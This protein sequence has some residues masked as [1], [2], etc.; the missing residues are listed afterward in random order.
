MIFTPILFICW[1][2]PFLQWTRFIQLLS[3]FLVISEKVHFTFRWRSVKFAAAKFCILIESCLCRT[4]SDDPRSDLKP[5]TKVPIYI[6]DYMYASCFILP[7]NHSVAWNSTKCISVIVGLIESC[8]CLTY[9]DDPRCT[10]VPIYFSDYR[11]ACCLILPYNCCAY[12]TL[13]KTFSYT[14]IPEQMSKSLPAETA[15]RQ[16]GF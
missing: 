12:S 6:S 16:Y 5:K 10:N 3:C 15:K 9:S 7:Y 13:S 14:C 2:Q 8:L 1:H 4:S 11:Y